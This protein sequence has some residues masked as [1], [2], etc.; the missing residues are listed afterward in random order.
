MTFTSTFQHSFLLAFHQLFL[1][2]SFSSFLFFGLFSQL[3]RNLDG[4][5]GRASPSPSPCLCRVKDFKLNLNE[6]RGGTKRNDLI[7]IWH[8]EMRE[9]GRANGVFISSITA[10]YAK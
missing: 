7:W 1:L 4:L 9:G 3:E 2:S 8:H 5:C 10:V 6:L